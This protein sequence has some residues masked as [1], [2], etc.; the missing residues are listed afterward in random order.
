MLYSLQRGEE[1]L[2][3]RKVTKKKGVWIIHL[4]DVSKSHTHIDDM[5]QDHIYQTL[6]YIDFFWKAA[7]S[8][9]NI[10]EERRRD[11]RKGRRKTEKNKVY[12]HKYR[13]RN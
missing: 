13:N 9:I 7:Y 12:Y 11:F 2:D 8:A 6:I 3:K 5:V 1:L 4:D 10:K